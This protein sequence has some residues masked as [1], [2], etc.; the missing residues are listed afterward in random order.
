[1]QFRAGYELIYSFPQ[2]TPIVL[3]VNIHYSITSGII[4][5]DRL[6]T[7]PFTPI[8]AYRDAFGN[9]CHRLLAP[10]GRVRLAADCVISDSG[11][12]DEIVSAA[13]QDSIQDLPE[14]TIVFLMGSRYCETDLLS[15]TA[16]DL[17]SGTPPGH[18]RVQAICD[19]PKSCPVI[20]GTLRRQ[21]ARRFPY[22]V[23]YCEES[24]EI[25]ILAIAHLK[26]RPLYW[27]GRQ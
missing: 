11:Q 16:W 5:P 23:I 25:R 13:W 26:H 12:P 18:A 2:P 1:M 6:I 20:A 21:L 15:Q 4:V 24:D 7:E 14:E 9:R 22:G 19:H 8:T 10:A 27:A 17:F 3:V